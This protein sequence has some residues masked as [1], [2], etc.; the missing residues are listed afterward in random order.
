VATWGIIISEVTELPY[1]SNCIVHRSRKVLLK[2]FRRQRQRQPTRANEEDHQPVPTSS[3]TIKT[4]SDNTQK[5][6]QSTYSPTVN[7]VAEW[8]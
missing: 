2:N 3:T 6:N 8:H 5:M 1:S 4:V 7:N